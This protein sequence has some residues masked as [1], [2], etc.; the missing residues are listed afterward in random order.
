MGPEKKISAKAQNSISARVGDVVY[1]ESDTGRM[2]WYAAL[3]F[4]F[5]LLAGILTWGIVSLF[6]T[7]HLWLCIGGF[8]AFF[9]CLIAVALYSK[10]VKD[11]QIDIKI[12]ELVEKD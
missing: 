8:G 5:P 10:L 3:I 4:I 11:K 2:L 1:I 12:V 6:T 9:I 7:K